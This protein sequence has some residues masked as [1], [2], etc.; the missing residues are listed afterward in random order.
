MTQL[1]HRKDSYYTP[2]WE[3][4]RK[5]SPA[6]LTFVCPQEAVPRILKALIKRKW[7]AQKALDRNLG[8]L[9]VV[10]KTPSD[11]KNMAVTV[12]L[13]PAEITKRIL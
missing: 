8:K 7:L 12:V 5:V 3:A 6:E 10:S 1:I 2:L 4:V 11:N 13:K 9:V